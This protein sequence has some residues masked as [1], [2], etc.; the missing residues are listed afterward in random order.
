LTGEYLFE[1]GR[2][3]EAGDLNVELGKGTIDGAEV[4]QVLVLL[5]S[6]PYFYD[7]SGGLMVEFYPEKGHQQL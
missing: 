3:D 7:D 1:E 6:E 5:E 4:G 2:R